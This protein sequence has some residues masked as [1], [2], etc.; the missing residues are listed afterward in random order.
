ML[1]DA[2]ALSDAQL[3]EAA[4]LLA[5]LNEASF[6]YRSG[7]P[8]RPVA[9]RAAAAVRSRPHDAPRSAGRRRRPSWAA[10]WRSCASGAGELQRRGL[11]ALV[12]GRHTRSVTGAGVDERL[13]AAI[14]AE[15]REL[16]S[17]SDVRKMQ[18][19]ARVASRL[20]RESGEPLELPSLAADVQPDR[21]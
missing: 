8:G 2:G 12:D 15:A 18:F 16:A 21:R 17:A 7:D 10:R 4:E 9:G 3:R 5:H 20:A 6:G 14:I 19:R 11:A 13:R 1:L